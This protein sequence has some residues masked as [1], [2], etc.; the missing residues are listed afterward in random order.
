[1]LASLWMVVSDNLHPQTDCVEMKRVGDNKSYD[2][3]RDL[4]EGRSQSRE[5]ETSPCDFHPVVYADLR[6]ETGFP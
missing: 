3:A 2:Q 6:E 5:S 4:V 1:M